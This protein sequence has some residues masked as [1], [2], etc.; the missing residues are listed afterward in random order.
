MCGLVKESLLH[1]FHGLLTCSFNHSALF[2]C[3]VLCQVTAIESQK[4]VCFLSLQFRRG[5]AR[6]RT[7]H[8]R[9]GR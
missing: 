1:S 7:G 2:I 3:L 9:R 5:R 8:E 4:N 6:T